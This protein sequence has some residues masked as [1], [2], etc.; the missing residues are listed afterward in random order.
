MAPR[1]QPAERDVKLLLDLNRTWKIKFWPIGAGSLEPWQQPYRE[2]FHQIEQIKDI[3]FGNYPLQDTLDQPGAARKKLLVREIQSNATQCD[4]ENENE[5]GWIN[6]VG[7][8]VFRRLNGFDI[9]W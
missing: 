7:S 3:K 5:A 8:L 4:N 2:L 1:H 9:I 6:N